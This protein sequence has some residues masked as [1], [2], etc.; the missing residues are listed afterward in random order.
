VHCVSRNRTAATQAIAIFLAA[1]Q[2]TGWLQEA[3]GFIVSLF[4]ALV[5]ETCSENESE[6][7]TSMV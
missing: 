5:M 2:S 4:V 1:K 3:D 7:Q 6:K